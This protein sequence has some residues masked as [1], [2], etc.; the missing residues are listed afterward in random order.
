MKKISVLCV[1]VS[2]GVTSFAAD[3]V[4]MS[5]SGTTGIF[6]NATSWNPEIAGGPGSTDT[7]KFTVAGSYGVAFNAD[8]ATMGL[9]I[10]AAA[11]GP[12]VS[13]DLGGYTWQVGSID[14]PNAGIARFGGGTLEVALAPEVGANRKLILDSGSTRFS[15]A[16]QLRT[17]VG[18]G[19]IE[20]NGGDHVFTAGIYLR[21]APS[22][23]LSFRMTG[24]SALADAG[25]GSSSFYNSSKTSLEGGTLE[26]A[27]Y[28]HTYAGTV[29][30]IHSNATL[31]M[32]GTIVN[33]GRTK[34][35]QAVINIL[36]GSL[37]AEGCNFQ[38]G[39]DG[40]QSMATGIVN[41]A[42]GLFRSR[43]VR[44]GLTS[45]QSV[46][47]V[48]QT[49]GRLEA[50]GD[51]TLGHTSGSGFY[52]LSGGS[53]WCNDLNAGYAAGVTG[54]VYQTGGALV[55]SNALN[56]GGTAANA[57]GIV[58][59]TGGSLWVNSALKVG[60][61]AQ[62]LGRMYFRG[63]SLYAGG[64]VTVGDAAGS[65]G[66]LVI[67]GGLNEMTEQTL[68]VGYSAG[69]TGSLE[70]SGG[71]NVFKTCYFGR[72]GDGL[73]RITGGFTYTTNRAIV[74]SYAPGTGRMEL[75]GGVLA[76]PV[77][78]GRDPLYVA[79]PGGYSE[80]VFDGGTL[81]YSVSAGYDS[82]FVNTFGKATLTGRGAV[83][84][85][86]G[87]TLRITQ[88]LSNETGHAGSFTK[89]GAGVL[90]L[91]SPDNAFTGRVTVEE[92]ELATYSTGSIRLTGGAVVEPGALLNLT[93]GTVL[94]ALT[95]SGT[96][97]RIDGALALKSGLTLTNGLGAALGGSGV[98]TG[99]VV[100]AAGSAVGRDKADAAGPL[101]VTGGATFETGAAVRL[102]GYTEQ[103][104]A[105]GIPLVQA[106]DGATLQAPGR[107]PATLDGASNSTWF[108]KV[109]QDGRTLVTRRIIAGTLIGVQ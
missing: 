56:V 49:G 107:L 9:S 101:L 14:F 94:D 8:A 65:T 86:N 23:N 70:I 98:V 27:G 79:L 57:V 80:I 64:G 11:P 83:V 59:N 66:E 103:E 19:P 71:T 38:L 43:Y 85:S 75:S 74:G 53:A 87:G 102:T 24:G 1:A 72:Y 44:C 41:L 5:G 4:W 12:D 45:T 15:G 31:N 29:I 58:T 81:R 99:S 60:T 37:I 48:N 77:I 39:V 68:S 20:V 16:S 100:F 105:A 97:S 2:V 109:T 28:M 93:T 51:L 34:N 88:A 13:F 95:A 3:Y 84:D 78:G 104:L 69:S 82:A 73:T 63:E 52:N 46:G 61:S 26:V 67:A 36:G 35:A 106:G 30:D 6:Q 91:S 33:H 54:T 21:S 47:I 22:G 55:V 92:G 17:A 89:K 18:G 96:V 40:K 76:V 10:G 90:R 32:I 25:S 62:T 7:G 108:A 50:T 42:D